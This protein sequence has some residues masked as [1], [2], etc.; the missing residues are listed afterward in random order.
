MSLRWCLLFQ[1]LQGHLLYREHGH[2]W[3]E[4]SSDG[5]CVALLER[6]G[7]ILLLYDYIL[8]ENKASSIEKR[9]TKSSIESGFKLV[10]ETDKTSDERNEVIINAGNTMEE[11]VLRLDRI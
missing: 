4:T 11:G 6:Q 2:R 3:D 9:R 10:Y 7:H 1:R 5:V 8:L